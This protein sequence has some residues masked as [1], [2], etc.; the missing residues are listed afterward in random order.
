MAGGAN[1]GP[2][3]IGRA[4]LSS[5]LGIGGLDGLGGLDADAAVDPACGWVAPHADATTTAATTTATRT[6]RLPRAAI[7]GT[8]RSYESLYLKGGCLLRRDQYGHARLGPIPQV[9]ALLT[10]TTV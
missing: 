7:P 9:R 2:V 8:D 10:L 3:P 4:S 6:A 1:R 5:D